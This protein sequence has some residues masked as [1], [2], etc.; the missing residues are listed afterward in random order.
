MGSSTIPE[1]EAAGECYAVDEHWVDRA[2]RELLARQGQA[3][4]WGYRDAGSPAVEPTATAGLALLAAGEAAAAPGRRRPGPGPAAGR[5][6]ARGPRHTTSGWATPHAMLLWGALDGFD[7]NRR[8]AR[9]WLLSIG[10]KP[11]R[12]DA[13]DRPALGH[14]ASLIGWSWVGGTHSWLEP[15]ATAVLA[16]IAAGSRDHPRVREGLRLIVDRAIPG[17]GW[18]YGNKA[19]YGT[20]LRPQP[21]PTGLGLLALAAGDLRESPAAA[22]AIAYLR[23]VLPATHAAASV[24]WGV[25]G[26]R[27]HDACP[28]EA[29]SWLS[30]AYDR[31]AGAPTR[32]SAPASSCWRRPP[33]AAASSRSGPPRTQDHETPDIPD[34]R[35]RRRG[36]RAGWQAGR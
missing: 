34:G 35:G 26:L 24:G 21:G 3:G 22:P 16:L 5:V 12:E 23:R 14:D 30:S 18:N 11:V 1:I 13:A 27:A 19:V 29:D 15:T 20:A 6:N 4:W 7:D 2:R 32:P 28:P 31:I 10:G 33:G 8:K 17:G 36:G 25:L 9:D